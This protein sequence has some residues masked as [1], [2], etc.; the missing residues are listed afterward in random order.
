MDGTVDMLS[1]WII[2]SVGY[3][4]DPDRTDYLQIMFSFGLPGYH[5][6]FCSNRPA[7]PIFDPVEYLVGRPLSSHNLVSF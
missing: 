6:L 3:G 2:P 1:C 5:H 4:T 7:L